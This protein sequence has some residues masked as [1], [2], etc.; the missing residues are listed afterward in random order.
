MVAQLIREARQILRGKWQNGRA[1]WNAFTPRGGTE[2]GAHALESVM[3]L[4]E[5]HK[6]SMALV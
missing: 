3:V 4:A 2:R 1:P 5:S 6:L